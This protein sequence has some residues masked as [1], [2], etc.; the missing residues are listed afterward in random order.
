LVLALLTPLEAE[1]PAL[2]DAKPDVETDA[3]SP[4]TQTSPSPPYAA[5]ASIMVGFALCL[6]VIVFNIG[7]AIS[8]SAW[9]ADLSTCLA[10]A[11]GTAL[12]YH[13]VVVWR[14]L[15]TAEPEN[16]TVLQLRPRRVLRASIVLTVLTLTAAGLVGVAIGKSRREA[17]QLEADLGEIGV[18]GQRISAARSNVERTVES[19][20]QMYKKVEP[21]VIALKVV[22]ERL[23]DE[24]AVF[25]SKFPAQHTTTMASVANIET[26]LKRMKLLTEQ[27]AVA[28]QIELVP[29]TSQFSAWQSRMQPL[30]DREEELDS[31]K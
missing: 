31:K 7:V 12:V 14:R 22:M 23:K 1:G 19:Y 24:L 5:F 27:I 10:G 28:K 29:D 25:D 11:V 26:G 20:V 2:A 13:A 15:V 17:K 21:D 3:A 18:I 30:L 8:R 4:P 6:S 16:D 9:D